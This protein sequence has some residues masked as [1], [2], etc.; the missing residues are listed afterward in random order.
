[1]NQ[2]D[3]KS[4][5][6][7]KKSQLILII[8]TFVVV[9]ALLFGSEVYLWQKSSA[10]LDQAMLNVRK[11]FQQQINELQ[12][13]IETLKQNSGS[14]KERIPPA[15]AEKFIADQAK[16]VISA[17]KS[18][19]MSKLSTF[20][21]L[22]KGVRF[23]PYSHINLDSDPVFTAIQIKNIFK[24][25]T[26]DT[27]GIYDGSGL[28]IEL[29]FEDY[30]KKFIYDQDFANA[31]EIAYNQIIGR[32]NMINNNFEVY[33]ESIIVEYHFSGFDPQYEGMDWESLRL[34]FEEKDNFWYLVGIIHDQWTI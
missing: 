6:E 2:Q 19:D 9:I 24:D 34:V 17:I 13:E 1:M 33:P 15:E 4:K 28:P 27:W 16:E 11:E 8:I 26:K 25:P 21:H 23:S 12:K 3:D 10:E 29:T 18:K 7:L 31:K 20:I 14:A 22:E 32:G 5:V 30:Y